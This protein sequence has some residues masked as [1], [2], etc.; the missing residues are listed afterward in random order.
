MTSLVIK[1]KPKPHVVVLEERR[2]VSKP[3]I[4]IAEV[5]EPVVEITKIEIEEVIELP[6]IKE[7]SKKYHVRR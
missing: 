7:E 5:I 1:F 3:M 4:P 6:A 2:E